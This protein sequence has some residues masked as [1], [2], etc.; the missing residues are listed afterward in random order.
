MA[1]Q[2][3]IWRGAIAAAMGAATALGLKVD[4]AIVL[5]DSNKLTVRL[6]PCDAVARVAEERARRW[7]EFEIGL[8]QGLADTDSPVAA[9]EPRVEPVPYVRDGFVVTL[10]TYYE[11]AQSRNFTPADYA[12]ALE[13]LHACMRQIDLP[14][15]HFTD[16]IGDAQRLV[17]S[18]KQTPELVDADRA[19]LTN[20]LRSMRESISVRAAPEQLLHGEPHPGNVLRTN[21]GLVFIDL[22]TC[23]RGPVEFDLAYVPEEVC[24]QYPSAHPQLLYECRILMLAMVAAW[25]SDRN[26]QL[27]NGQQEARRFLSELGAAR[28]GATFST[29]LSRWTD[30]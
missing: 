30:T 17:E 20:T 21:K 18:R 11:A 19:L 26:D 2:R 10:W 29:P 14:T 3:K 15:P 4:D 1:L 25:R 27:P 8:A 16:R 28:S 22:E 5:H 12:H 23:C 7:A 6:L 24:M 13:R 9:L